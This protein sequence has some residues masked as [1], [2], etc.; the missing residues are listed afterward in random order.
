VQ[1]MYCTISHTTSE[2]QGHEHAML[3]PVSSTAC[4]TKQLSTLKGINCAS[5]RQCVACMRVR[6]DLVQSL[7]SLTPSVMSVV[8]PQQDMQL[9]NSGDFI[10][11][12]CTL[13]YSLC[14][15]Q[16]LQAV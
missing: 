6:P 11:S 5:Q 8:R 10:W 16:A 2:Q 4:I 12:S 3:C 7:L 9:M 1:L 13:G 15:L 14:T